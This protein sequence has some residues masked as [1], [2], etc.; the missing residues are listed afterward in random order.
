MKLA[1][2]NINSE[3]IQELLDIKV[4]WLLSSSNPLKIILF[5]SVM[6]GNM[7]EASDIDLIVVYPNDTNLKVVQRAIS[8]T[9]PINDWPHDLLLYTTESFEK[10]VLKG[11]GVCWLAQKEG[12]ILFQRR[13]TNVTK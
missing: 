4:T 11:G 8:K 7:T 10:S 6:T 9:R 5:G 3:S 13:K 12:K 2:K 1:A